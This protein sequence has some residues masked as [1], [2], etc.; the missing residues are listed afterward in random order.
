[1]HFLFMLVYEEVSNSQS[2][3]YIHLNPLRPMAG[4]PTVQSGQLA[5]GHTHLGALKASGPC[6]EP[7]HSLISADFIFHEVHIP[8]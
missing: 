7:R 3:S 4:L 5:Q 2:E 1:M 8:K 6:C